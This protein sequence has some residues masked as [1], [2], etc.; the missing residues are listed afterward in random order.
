MTEKRPEEVKTKIN[1]LWEGTTY[2]LEFDRDTA[3]QTESHYD[4]PLS[5]VQKGKVSTFEPLFRGALLKHHPK[6][7]TSTASK[8]FEVVPNRMELFQALAGLYAQSLTSLL[9]ESDDEGKA[10]TW[11]LA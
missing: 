11:T 3:V 5:D 7:K 2:V 8:L 1:I 9:E 4:I 10:A 6:M